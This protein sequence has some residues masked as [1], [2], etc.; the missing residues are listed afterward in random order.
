MKAYNY[1]CPKCG[2]D[3]QTKE[4]KEELRSQPGHND[5]N[6]S[7]YD[8]IVRS[9][10]QTVPCPHC[11]GMLPDETGTLR[12]NPMRIVGGPLGGEDILPGLWNKPTNFVPYNSQTLGRKIKN[13]AEIK[14]AFV[15]MWAVKVAKDMRPANP[16]KIL[17][18]AK[19]ESASA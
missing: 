6:F 16:K 15:E 7:K 1:E 2:F 8:R 14:E 9:S 10:D 13:E 12:H 18:R 5:S 3:G 4:E 17:R 11:D 19:P